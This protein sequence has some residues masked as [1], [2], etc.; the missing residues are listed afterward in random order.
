MMLRA[1]SMQMH[2]SEI[3]YKHKPLVANWETDVKSACWQNRHMLNQWLEGALKRG[4]ISQAELAR[5]L[6]RSL[7]RSIDRAAVNKMLSGDRKIDANEMLM[8]A[9]L[10]GEPPPN[11]VISYVPLLSWVSAGQLADAGAELP[12]DQVKRL[13]FVDLEPGEFFA[14]KVEG[15]SMDRLSPSGSTILVNRA[16]RE[17]IQNRC[18]VFAVRGE[19]T[20][21]RWNAEPPYL[22]PHSWNAAHQ[23]IFIK[24]KSDLEVVGRVRR[25]ILDL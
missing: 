13:P 12:F 20:Y 4:G 21:K 19:T 17:L 25:T 15:D 10:T 22:A 11:S 9:E 14:L 1:G 2:C 7:G 8:I 23:P 3:S 5:Q 18:Y 16:D 24:K 6:T